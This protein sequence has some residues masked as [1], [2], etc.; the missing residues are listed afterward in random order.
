V[1]QGFEAREVVREVREAGAGRRREDEVACAGERDAGREGGIEIGGRPVERGE[2]LREVGA[3][4]L[5]DVRLDAGEG[6][7]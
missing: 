2:R 1:H 5:P 7:P 4:D 3:G 6:R